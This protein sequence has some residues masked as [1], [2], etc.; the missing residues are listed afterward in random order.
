MPTEADNTAGLSPDYRI[1]PLSQCTLLHELQIKS[2]SMQEATQEAEWQVIGELIDSVH[3]EINGGM[4]IIR[5]WIEQSGL[6]LRLSI[7]TRLPIRTDYSSTQDTGVFL[8]LMDTDQ[9]PETGQPHIGIGSEFNV[10]AVIGEQ[11]IDGFVDPTGSLP[12]GGTAHVSVNGNVVEIIIT[13]NQVADP[14]QFSWSAS[15]FEIINDLYEQGNQ[16]TEVAIAT[17]LPAPTPASRVELL[18]PLLMLSPNGSSQSQLSAVLWDAEGV[19][20]DHDEHAVSY[21][22]QPPSELVTLDTQTGMVEAIEVPGSFWETPHILAV[23]DGRLSSNQSTIRI[24]DTDLGFNHQYYSGDRVSFYLPQAVEGIDLDTIT[25]MHDIVLA[26]D[27]SFLAQEFAVGTTPWNGS[28][29]YFVLDIGEDNTVPCGLSGNPVRLGWTLGPGIELGGSCYIDTSSQSP[30][31]FIIFHELAHNFTLWTSSFMQFADGYSPQRGTYV[32]G[33]ASI[34]ALWTIWSVN[35]CP[36]RLNSQALSDLET[37]WN[38]LR[39]RF[40]FALQDYQDKGAD[41]TQI[42][43]D[44]LDGIGFDLYDRYGPVIWFDLFSL[45]LPVNEPLPCPVETESQQATLFAAAIS[46]SVGEDLRDLFRE[47]YGF[48]IDDLAWADLLSCAQSRVSA[49]SFSEQEVCDFLQ[50]TPC[51]YDKDCSDNNVCTTDSCVAGF[52]TLPQ[53]VSC[54]DGVEC[55]MDHCDELLGCQN[56]PRANLC[57]DGLPCTIDSCNTVQ[58]CVHEN[59]PDDTPCEDGDSCSIDTK[60]LEGE[61]IASQYICIFKDGFELIPDS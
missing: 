9:N 23:G 42:D 52:C 51:R 20:L 49:R 13:L 1:G 12:G 46:A 27:Y 5:A 35:S 61:C 56:E 45:F 59:Q 50:G 10:R 34:G 7:E 25:A 60:C 6:M 19:V 26:T 48:P 39:N 36:N 4:D 37:E 57:D 44:V 33:L 38:N 43:P 11:S 53:P 8:W 16:E 58:G 41:Y 32:E 28:N 47:S 24:T 31:W 18:P 40:L 17:V 14:G 2:M 3:V 22:E 15:S 30:Q 54:N 21:F 55:T 29:Q